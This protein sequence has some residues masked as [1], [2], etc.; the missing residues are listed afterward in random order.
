MVTGF[1]SRKRR[2]VH[3][4]KTPK[5]C[6]AF[7]WWWEKMDEWWIKRLNVDCCYRQTLLSFQNELF[8]FTSAFEK[9]AMGQDADKKWILFLWV[10]DFTT[11]QKPFHLSQ[12][13]ILKKNLSLIY[14]EVK[15]CTS[16]SNTLHR[17]WDLQLQRLFFR[18]IFCYF[19]ITPYFTCIW[20]VSV[21]VSL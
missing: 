19:N 21:A 18:N 11:D 3:Q 7:R 5:T 8:S 2:C 16:N 12:G 4:E 15:T 6:A 14:N 13:C 20:A 10:V 17:K 1:N 9:H